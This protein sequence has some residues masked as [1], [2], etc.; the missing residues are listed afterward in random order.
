[1]ND[2]RLSFLW[3]LL[4]FGA[5]GDDGSAVPR[6]D[7]SA[8]GPDA[9]QSDG[10]SPTMGLGIEFLDPDHGP[11][12]GGTEV[13]L[14]GRGFAEGMTIR[15][16]GRMVEPLDVEL[17]DERRVVV[18]TP[19][20]DPG[21]ATVSVEVGAEQAELADGFRY[22]SLTVDPPTGSVAGGTYVL[23]NGFGTNFT[24]GDEVRFGSELLLN[25]QVLGEQQIA[26]L[27]PVGVA[28]S[29]DVTVSGVAGT[30]VASDAYTYITTADP[31]G[32]GMGGGPIDGTLNV[33]VID[34]YTQDG[35][36]GAFVT[37][38]DPA[39][40]PHR[41]YANLYGEITFSAPGLVGP[42]SVTAAALDYESSSMVVF[43]AR[44]VTI[45]LVPIIPP[46]FGPLPPGRQA[47]TIFG[48]ILFGSATVVGTPEWGLVPEPRT[49]TEFKRAFV[50][51]TNRDP[52][53]FNPDPG[54]GGTVD[55]T[56]NATAWEFSIIARPAALAVVAVAGL[57][58]PVRDPD[59]PAGP[60]PPGA[61]EAFALGTAR[62]VLVGP[63]EVVENVEVVIDIPLDTAVQIELEDPPPLNTPG[64]VGP[65][66]YDVDAYVD[67]GGEGVIALPDAAATFPPGE[68]EHLLP[69]LAPLQTSIAD[70]SYLIYAGAYSFFETAPYSVRVV[71]GVRDLSVPVEVDE[72]LG[73][74]RATDPAP[75][76]TATAPHLVFAPEGGTG[77]STFNIHM[78]SASDGTP[79]WRIYT[80]GSELT[81]PLWDLET[82]AGLPAFPT[83]PVVWVMYE[84]TVPGLT[85]DQWTY[86][87]L[88]SNFWSAYAVDVQIVT[89]PPYP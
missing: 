16:D 26:G 87:H 77:Q 56:T 78:L 23:I 28:G 35:V 55:Y 17:V 63:G 24:D 5:C 71:R 51:T 76:G 86:R 74:P 80:R 88:N 79:L 27:T 22:E 39:T 37:V 1:V 83:D 60:L 45:F 30:V 33:T 72:F 62:G 29:V 59:G 68:T 14:R 3:A 6:D 11:F 4:I 12:S 85:F 75:N 34:A 46:D 65:I 52:F 66:E 10:L 50:Y 31:F 58:D 81:V 67:L 44:D 82:A 64:W 48:H 8:P 69:R 38:G 13:I 40:T 21:P 53:S 84:I 2:R 36:D 7:A 32:G 73:T 61:F 57:Y 43:D 41:G 18:S 49:P 25:V 42:V 89:I 15:F 20:G 47:G 70:A 19:P 9:P 54:S